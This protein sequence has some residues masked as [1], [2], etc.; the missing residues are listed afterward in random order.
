MYCA[1]RT[2]CKL[3]YYLNNETIIKVTL[4]F[5][6]LKICSMKPRISALAA[7]VPKYIATPTIRTQAYAHSYSKT[8]FIEFQGALKHLPMLR[9]VEF[10]LKTGIQ[11]HKHYH[12]NC[13]CV[14]RCVCVRNRT[15][16]N[17]CNVKLS[18]SHTWYCLSV[19]MP[20][21]IFLLTI[22]S[23]MHS[24]YLRLL[25]TRTDNENIAPSLN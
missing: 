25:F 10:V 13:E 17:E 7:T 16:R 5:I 8:R 15:P 23:Q 14:L 4:K 18:I 24:H 21:F 11:I 1:S 2:K 3:V 20:V 6:T 12:I 19:I 9:R 22:A